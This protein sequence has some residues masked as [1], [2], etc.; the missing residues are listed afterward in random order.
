MTPSACD[1]SQDVGDIGQAAEFLA[2]Q[3]PVVPTCSATA[4][5]Q[6][7]P[8]A[9]L[10]VD[11][12]DISG[13]NVYA[14]SPSFILFQG[15]ASAARTVCSTFVT[16]LLEHI[17]GW[18][19]S[20]FSSWLGSS[21]PFSATYHDAIVAGNGFLN[22]TD[23]TQVK[24][25]DLMA[26]EYLDTTDITGHTALVNGLPQP[27]TPTSPFVTGTTQYAVP[28]LDSASSPHGTNDTRVTSPTASG[29]GIGS[30]TMRVYA[31]SSNQVVGYTWSTLSSSVFRAQSIRNLVFGRL[32]INLN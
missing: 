30:G 21:S 16:I 32:N 1:D 4:D 10:L 23:I 6:I 27:V 13:Q 7:M 12:L 18:S 9:R 2:S 19:G 24:V 15:T 22:I 8:T 3:A 26:I 14:T 5:Q 20:T 28:V 31:N 17:C 29:A 25:G 11:D